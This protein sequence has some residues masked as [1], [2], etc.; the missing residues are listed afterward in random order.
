MAELPDDPIGT[1]WLIANCDVVPMAR[2]PV[3]SRI[4]GR[5][6]TEVIDGYRL[7]TYPELM[8]PANDTALNDRP[9]SKASLT[10]TRPPAT[11][12]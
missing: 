2:P 12:S 9:D 8:R 4:G 10:T 11:R 7:E 3:L 6:A 5:H 1:A